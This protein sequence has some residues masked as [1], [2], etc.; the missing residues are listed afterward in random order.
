MIKQK[1]QTNTYLNDKEVPSHWRSLIKEQPVF[2]DT[3]KIIPIDKKNNRFRTLL[4]NSIKNAKQ[5]IMMCSFILSD[6]DII[7][8]LLKAS[9]R[10]VRCYLLF[11]TEA[12]LS[13]EY[14]K[15]QSEFD[16]KTLK[17]HKQ[18]LDRLAGKILARTCD[19]LH[20]KFLLVDYGNPEQKGFI[21]TANFTKEALT[22]NQE[23]GVILSDSEINFLFN[24]FVLGFWVESKNEL[25]RK[26]NWDAVK[27]I[28][29]KPLKGNN[30]IFYTTS[31]NQTLKNELEKII[32]NETKELVVSSYGFDDEHPIVELLIN[33]AQNINLT[34]ITRPREKNHKV[35]EKFTN[36]GAKVVA[37]DYLHAKFILSP[38][39]NQ[40]IIMTANL[41]SKG[42]ETG[43]EVGIKITRKYFDELLTISRVWID[44]APLIWY[45]KTSIKNLEPGT[46]KIPKGKDYDTI[47]IIDEFI[48]E[49]KI[50]PQ[51]LHKM[52]K[53]L[54]EEPKL[55]KNLDN[56]LPKKIIV[57][58]T[59]IPPVLPKDAVK[60]E[61]KQLFTSKKS[62]RREADV[63]DKEIKFP[64][65][66]Y[67]LKNIYYVVVKSLKDLEKLKEFPKFRQT[68][69]IVTKG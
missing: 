44:S 41:E 36:A 15:E 7:D 11:S 43:Y 55:K 5:T 1:E 31:S 34:I 2:K 16:E 68:V 57:K 60:V 22:R 47:E 4:L 19:H 63:K 33:K 42:L 14:K 49:Q 23:L 69:R 28:N 38:S 27:L 32:E 62:R 30:Q 6:P 24:F 25:V 39:T 64:F 21:S 12:Q 51:D 13:K 48:D 59:I 3:N 37:Y 45:N 9:E 67:R 46:I 66:T 18:M 50:E 26:N 40:G 56:K 29:L 53:L 8:S 52:E 61:S 35:I 54:K 20:A 65:E 10:G 17:E 58:R